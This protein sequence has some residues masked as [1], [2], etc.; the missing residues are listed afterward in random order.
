MSRANL[1]QLLFLDL[2]GCFS[3]KQ[4]TTRLVTFLFQSKFCLTHDQEHVSEYGVHWNFFLTLAFLPVLQVALHPVIR[5]F[6]ISALGV[7]L[8]IGSYLDMISEFNAESCSSSITLVICPS[9]GLHFPCS[10]SFLDQCQQRRDHLPY[11][12]V[13][14]RAVVRKLNHRTFQDTSRSTLWVCLLEH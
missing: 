11:R 7:G 3:S 9:P 13:W 12:F 4:Q 6:S 5:H 10:Q 1:Y 14:S 8:G 2:S